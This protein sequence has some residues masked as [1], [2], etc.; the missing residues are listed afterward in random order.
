[1][2][3]DTLIEKVASKTGLSKSAAGE[4]VSATVDVITGALSEGDSVAITGFG[5]F[6]ASSRAARKGV[7]PRTGEKI[8][9]PATK[10]PKFKAGKSL[11][12]AVK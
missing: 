7:N 5:T 6:S 4:A 11:K 9:I 8:N 1:M 10:L 3:K 2:T 12:D